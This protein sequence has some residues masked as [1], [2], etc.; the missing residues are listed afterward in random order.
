M[1]EEK[2]SLGVLVG[3]P[4][5]GFFTLAAL[6]CIAVGIRMFQI[7]ERSGYSNDWDLPAKSWFFGGLSVLITTVGITGIAMYP[8][9]TEYHRWVPVSGSVSQVDSRLL[10]D[11]NG[12]ATQRYV[13]RVNGGRKEY[14]CDDTRCSLLQV[15]DL[16]ELSCIR[17]W[18]YSG[19]DGWA[20]NYVRSERR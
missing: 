12:G 15:N 19:T 14:A 5:A 8:Y 16:L 10:A 20:C 4:V 11:G 7:R 6:A 9:S 17:E 18:Q 13:V 1:N 3:L 2:W